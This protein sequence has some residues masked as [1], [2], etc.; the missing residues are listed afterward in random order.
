[1]TE[2]MIEPVSQTLEV[3][4]AIL[5]YDVRRKDAGTE[6]VLFMIASWTSSGGRS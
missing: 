5:T 6:P 2:T 3:P 4:G 1:M